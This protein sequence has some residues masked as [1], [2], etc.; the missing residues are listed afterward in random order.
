M[1]QKYKRIDIKTKRLVSSLFLWNYKAAFKWRG[2]EFSDFRE[3]TSSDDA[4][5]IDW[6]VSAR[7]GK[8]IMRRYRE[9]REL[10][11]LFV[12]D[13]SESM[14]FWFQK[15]KIDT[16]IEIFYLIAFSGIQNG[17]KVWALL[18]GWE[19]TQF[20]PF[21]KGSIGLFKILDGIEKYQGDIWNERLDLTS[22]N[23]L[24][25]KNALTFVLT[26]KNEIDDSS[27]RLARLRN[28]II[29]INIFDSFENT[30]E[31]KSWILTL[32]NKNRQVILDLDNKKKKEKYLNLRNKKKWEF[33][34]ILSQN[35]I[36]RLEIDENTDIYQT[37]LS[38]MKTREL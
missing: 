25:V 20:I 12:L 2:L 31:G 9:E 30:L 14:Q 1:K 11:I 37:F 26:D 28:D 16:L 17:D 34:S 7:E 36:P 23:V 18:F 27:L 32:G 4:K 6:L 22:L 10:D 8:T 21:K 24:P 33:Q 29:C 15:K 13:L 3:Y 19:K 38:F 35:R 5:H